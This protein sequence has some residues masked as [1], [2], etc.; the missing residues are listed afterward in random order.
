MKKQVSLWL[1]LVSI[2][3]VFAVTFS[4]TFALAYRPRLPEE[5]TMPNA[6]TTTGAPAVS[7]DPLRVEELIR[8]IQKSWVKSLDGDLT[9]FVLESILLGTGDVYSNYMDPE[10]YAE[11]NESY[12]GDF[13]GIG[14]T[15]QLTEQNEVVIY[16]VIPNSPAAEGGYCPGD[17]LVAVNGT[18]LTFAQNEKNI[19]DKVGDLIRGEAGTYVDITVLRGDREI[20][21]HTERRAVVNPSVWSELLILNDKKVMYIMVTGFDYTTPIAFKNAVDAA[22]QGGADMIVFDMRN[23]PG[24]LLSVVATMLTYLVED[25]ALLCT[26]EYKT[27]SSEVRAGGYIDKSDPSKEPSL[28]VTEKGT[29]RYNQAYADHTLS[30]P[31][32]VLTN[33]NTASAAELFT[34]VLRDYE[35]A[36]LVGENTYGKG[37]MQVTYD[38]ENGYAVKLTV[39]YYTPPCGVNYDKTTEG[40]IGIAPDH[41]VIFTDE[42]NRFNLYTVDHTK[43][44]QFVTAFNA[45][46][47]GE[48][49][50][51]PSVTE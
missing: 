26:T 31:C 8:R 34:S 32:A 12:Y 20:T 43:D 24:G 10:E 35:L 3:L 48:K 1:F 16:N 14:I 37:C 6:A 2:L 5:T 44:R 45:L 25:D 30:L 46:T 49:L 9:E 29:I 42:E 50:P 7:F 22:E 28:I 27:S 23:N 13:V 38:L 36:T 39:A 15:V 19:L 41:E 4:L 40:P 33:K 47:K 17:L 11:Y 18:R 51:M 21:M